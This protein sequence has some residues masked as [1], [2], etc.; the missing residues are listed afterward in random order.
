M[1]IFGRIHAI[2]YWRDNRGDVGMLRSLHI[3]GV[4]YTD[5]PQQ[6]GKR[7]SDMT[8]GRELNDTFS[9]VLSGYFR[10]STGS[11]TRRGHRERLL[12]WI[13]YVGSVSLTLIV[14]K[15]NQPVTSYCCCWHCWVLVCCFFSEKK[16]WSERTTYRCAGRTSEGTVCP[17]YMFLYCITGAVTYL[18]C[19]IMTIII[20]RHHYHQIRFFQWLRKTTLTERTMEFHSE[21]PSHFLGRD[22]LIL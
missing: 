15:S 12:H 20:H 8:R 5:K 3:Q 18:F 7:S 22:C 19:N 1:L 10:L 2:N 13:Q 9:G 16:F 14:P 21:S 4:D 17:M 6:T 11:E